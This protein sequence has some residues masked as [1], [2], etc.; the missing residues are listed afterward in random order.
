MPSGRANTGA[1]TYSEPRSLCIAASSRDVKG[2]T[3][4]CTQTG[5]SRSHADF[6]ARLNKHQFALFVRTHGLEPRQGAPRI[7]TTTPH[8]YS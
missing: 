6:D 5:C 2:D 8:T 3:Y 7:T 4:E 1:P